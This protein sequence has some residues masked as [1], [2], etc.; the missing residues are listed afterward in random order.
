MGK[1]TP[2]H[3]PSANKHTTLPS[4]MPYAPD[5]RDYLTLHKVEETLKDAI[6]DVLKTKPNAPLNAIAD[7]IKSS[8]Y[9]FLTIQ[10]T[11][12]IKDWDAAR[13]FME[14]F[15]ELTKTEIGCVYY[16][17]SKTDTKLFCR[18][19]YVDAAATLAHIENVGATFGAML[20]SG[21]ATLDGIELHGPSAELEKCKGVFDAFGT[22]YWAVDSGLTFMSKEV[23]SVRAAQTIMTIQPTFTI[24]D[25]EA[26]RPVMDKFV[27]LT[28]S[29]TGCVYYGW[30][31]VGDK[32]FCREAYG[33]ATGVLAHIDNVGATF[34][35]FL[36][37]GAA[38]LDK[39]EL[40]GPKEE[41]EKCKTVFDAFGTAYWEIDSGFQNYAM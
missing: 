7:K 8:G 36:E 5:A 3:S 38:T 35:A 29:E 40:H 33:E 1:P 25:W 18:E 31:K 19:A 34:G 10:P 4:I 37:S 6:T 2:K 23:G 41:L 39:I 14:K 28:K 20:E 16:G 17:W 21:A 27:E 9:T 13:P 26:A 32:L 22:T 30:T 11:F 15:V 24:K 12:T